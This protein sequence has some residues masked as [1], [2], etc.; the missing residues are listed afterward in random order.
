MWSQN[1][2]PLLKLALQHLY[3]NHNCNR[4]LFI[5]ELWRGKWEDHKYR[6]RYERVRAH[7]HGIGRVR[8]GSARQIKFAYRK[9]KQC[10]SKESQGELIPYISSWAGMSNRSQFHQH[11]TRKFLVRKCFAQFFSSSMVLNLFELAAH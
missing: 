4:I 2:C 1:L 7:L 11:F 3:T 9:T 5:S 8:M 6:Q 10:N